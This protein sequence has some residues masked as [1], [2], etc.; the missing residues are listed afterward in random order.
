LFGHSFGGLLAYEAA[1][2]AVRDGYQQP[3]AVFVSACRPP[4]VETRFARTLHDLPD[5][6]LIAALDDLGAAPTAIFAD[7]ELRNLMLPAV[8]ADI[9]V[10]ETYEHRSDDV[11]EA[12]IV[13]LCGSEDRHADCDEMKRWSEFTSGP[14]ELLVIPGDH[15]F[16]RSNPTD[17]L[18]G[19]RDRLDALGE[20]L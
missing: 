2:A 3:D 13:A 9:E 18:A 19:I 14:F 7:P 12:P 8:R 5:D 11:L 16:V 15:F 4:D 6:E 17:I 10:C 20:T 1:R